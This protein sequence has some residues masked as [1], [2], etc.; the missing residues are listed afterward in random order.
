MNDVQQRKTPAEVV[1]PAEIMISDTGDR[2]AGYESRNSK[3]D[4][5][6]TEPKSSPK[7]LKSIED[8]REQT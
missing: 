6:P 7:A 3:R 5:P 4:A 8:G 2:R 1:P